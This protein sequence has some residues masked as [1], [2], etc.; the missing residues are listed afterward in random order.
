MIIPR[1]YG[2]QIKFLTIS[3]IWFVLEKRLLTLADMI[4]I[5]V[6]VKKGLIWFAV[7]YNKK[8]NHEP[9]SKLHKKQNIKKVFIQKTKVLIERINN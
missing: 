8:G 6:Y 2:E 3:Q 4:L 9:P 1:L 5:C 7:F